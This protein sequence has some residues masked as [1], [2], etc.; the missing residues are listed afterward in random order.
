MVTNASQSPALREKQAQVGCVARRSTNQLPVGAAVRSSAVLRAGIDR[1]I[2]SIP[3]R[4]R[5]GFG[6]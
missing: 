6:L 3:L 2:G 5:V 1:A 4:R